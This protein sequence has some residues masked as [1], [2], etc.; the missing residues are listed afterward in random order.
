M[1]LLTFWAVP[2]SPW[3]GEGRGRQC[4]APP[5]C[6]P[7]EGP[8]EEGRSVPTPVLT[9]SGLS[10][11]PRTTHLPTE[12]EAAR[13]LPSAPRPVDSSPREPTAP[14]DAG[15]WGRAAQVRGAGTLLGRAGRMLPTKA[16]PRL[17]TGPGWGRRRHCLCRREWGL[18]RQAMTSPRALPTPVWPPCL[19][20]FAGGQVS[21]SSKCQPKLRLLQG[22]LREADPR[23]TLL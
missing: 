22:L 10:L 23:P 3:E 13:P 19:C 14:T 21:L 1:R 16:G 2:K 6:R 11:P 9:V 17:R 5:F 18:A 4:P 20:P 15:R 12:R 7:A 8:D